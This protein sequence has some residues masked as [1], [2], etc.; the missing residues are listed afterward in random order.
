MTARA[1][2]A[3]AADTGAISAEAVAL[4]LEIEKA[5]ACGSVDVPSFPS[6]AARIRKVLADDDVAADQVV[7]VVGT[8]PA[9]AARVLQLANSAALNTTRQRITNLRTAVTRLGFI[10]VRSA[11]IAFAIVQLRKAECMRGLERE[12]DALWQRSTLVAALCYAIARRRTAINPDVALLAGLLHGIGRLYILTHLTRYP[13][14]RADREALEAVARDWHARV[15]RA[16]LVNWESPPEIIHAI[17]FFET[18]ERWRSGPP[19]L[20]DVLAAASVLA[21]HRGTL[22]LFELE[23]PGVTSCRTLG[24]D[25]G[26]S[27]ELLRES[28]AEVADLSRALGP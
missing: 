19:D 25:A 24:L 22:R 18:P 1:L 26:S 13:R 27:R 9:L 6:I 10:M 16:L 7:R 8:E 15:A 5:L 3:T 17:Q 2:A 20:T 11:S 21:E 28:E 23:L 12:L 14:L 4:A